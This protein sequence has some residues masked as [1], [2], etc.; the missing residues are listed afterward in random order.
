M[1]YESLYA[2]PGGRTE[3]GPYAGALIPLILAAVFYFVF[4]KGRNGEWVLATLLYPATV[5]LARRFRDMGMT[6]WML[7]APLGLDLAAIWMHMFQKNNLLAGAAAGI[8]AAFVLWGL[9]GK[10]KA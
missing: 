5:L 7:I 1:N 3:R 10:T 6:P 8:S 9:I 2:F 4:V